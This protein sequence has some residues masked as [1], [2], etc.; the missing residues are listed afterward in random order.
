MKDFE[1]NSISR[2]LTSVNCESYLSLFLQ[3]EITPKLLLSMDKEAF[4]DLGI[5]K[6]GDRLRLQLLAQILKTKE[7]KNLNKSSFEFKRNKETIEKIE[8]NVGA[9]NLSDK[10]EIELIIILNNGEYEEV[11]LKFFGLE[12]S[13]LTIR[14]KIIQQIPEIEN[15]ADNFTL[16]LL[17]S[18]VKPM[19]L[20]DVELGPFLQSLSTN[21]RKKNLL[22]LCPTDEQPS[23]EAINTFNKLT[24]QNKLTFPQNRSISLGKGIKS[25]TFTEFMGQRPPSS[26]I[27]TNLT[28]YFPKMDAQSLKQIARN[29]IRL[30][31]Y[32]QELLNANVGLRDSVF[33]QFSGLSHLSDGMNKRLSMLSVASIGVGVPM[34]VKETIGDLLLANQ[35][36][37]DLDEFEEDQGTLTNLVKAELQ[38]PSIDN[39]GVS[40]VHSINDTLKDNNSIIQLLDESDSEEDEVCFVDEY[41][42]I[43]DQSHQ[44]EEII[45]KEVTFGP[46]VWHKG[47]K[48]G[49][50]SFGFVYLGL[51]G[52]TGEIMAVKQVDIPQP[53]QNDQSSHNKSLMVSALKQEMSL[54]KEL[55]HPNI[56]RYLGSSEDCNRMYIFLEYI[57]GGSVSSMLKMYGP[58]E[59]LLIRNFTRQVLVGLKYL[60]SKGIIH[61]DIKGA[62]ILIDNNGIAKISDFGISKRLE[63]EALQAALELSST[64]ESPVSP[65]KISSKPKRDKR[66]SLQGS[67]Y[68]MAPE[69]V[70]QVASTSKA[71][72]WSLGCLIVEMMSGKHP[73][74]DF[75]QMQAIFRIGTNAKPEYPEGISDKGREFLD[76]TFNVDWRQRKGATEL[77][78][79]QFVK[80]IV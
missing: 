66:A 29:S 77:L 28:N 59:E 55:D 30:S 12:F 48:I 51:N 8:A 24:R 1:S 26:L 49:Q 43:S 78:S 58:F 65:T 45:K 40:P 64:P 22:I 34:H 21:E 25:S 13:S 10:F 37:L 41:L 68:W 32:G 56:V 72:I 73:F 54:L 2:L 44:L 18:D 14:R 33:S 11:E 57:S 42:S 35:E 7:G 74:P 19:I 4:V 16:Y 6:V 36:V 67:V 61:R 53:N 9:I 47:S 27:T 39:S 17:T 15:Y 76:E 5:L 38:P 75:T 3:N 20:H 50:G 71:D 79:H 52:L 80:G 69:I 60:H 62:N 70:K 46:T 23:L 31:K 63:G